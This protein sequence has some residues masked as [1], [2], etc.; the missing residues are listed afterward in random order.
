MRTEDVRPLAAQLAQL[1]P[2]SIELFCREST[3]GLWLA[4]DVHEAWP[5]PTWAVLAIVGTRYPELTAE[6]LERFHQS[7]TVPRPGPHGWSG[8]EV[9]RLC[10]VLQRRLELREDLQAL[11]GP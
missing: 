7:E 10:W 6:L 3:R 9:C 5:A 11:G 2:Q 8:F 4:A 1:D